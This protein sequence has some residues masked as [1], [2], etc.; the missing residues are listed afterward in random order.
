MHRIYMSRLR[1]IFLIAFSF[2]LAACTK[3]PEL[4]ICAA[5][6]A[7]GVMWP[8][9]GGGGLGVLKNAAAAEKRPH[10]LL[11]GDGWF[12]GTPEGVRDRGLDTARLMGAVG[13]DAVLAGPDEFTYGWRNLQ[14]VV[15][16][17]SLPA[18]GSNVRVPGGKFLLPSV[19][20]DFG[21][22]RVGVLGLLAD[23]Q[24]RRAGQASATP[25]VKN[26]LEQTRELAGDLK[27]QGVEFVVALLA[28]DRQETLAMSRQRA[29]ELAAAVPELS[30]VLVFNR[31]SG[32]AEA[33]RSGQS[34]L[35]V[36]PYVPGSVFQLTLALN[37]AAHGV[38][39]VAVRRLALD[40]SVYGEDA[41]IAAR[42]SALR[43]DTDRKLGRRVT[44]APQELSGEA[45]GNWA[46]DCLMRWGKGQAAFLNRGAL[47]SSIPAGPVTEKTLYQLYPQDDTVMIVKIRGAE[48]RQALEQSLDSPSSPLYA[49]GVSID[50]N[51]QGDP[52]MR[53]RAVAVD[54]TPIADNK[55]YKV[56]ATDF[57][58]A[59]GEGCA[60]L[61]QAVEFANT[62][63]PVRKVLRWCMAKNRSIAA[64]GG[65]RWIKEH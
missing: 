60:G 9:D 5:Q 44:S 4:V 64:P 48:L 11:G 1:L 19:V 54:G 34:W 65:Q 63:E 52:G 15:Q 32:E 40:A 50:Y 56:I 38:R 51:P 59:G 20:K 62:H 22:F 13:Y 29:A 24:H 58:L 7:H 35:A 55:L 33:V 8:D 49:G 2:G 42:V 61:S 23:E 16:E 53:I 39:N 10:L 26:E 14:Y 45:L 46:A 36:C 57:M 6:G 41:K 12:V 43:A 28:G 27:R 25:P 3:P 21:A 30:L 17:S 47:W 31:M 18:L 37:P